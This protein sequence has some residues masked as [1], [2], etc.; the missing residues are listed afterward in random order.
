M[1]SSRP[2][3]LTPLGALSLL[4]LVP[5]AAGGSEGGPERACLLSAYALPQEIVKPLELVLLSDRSFLITT[6]NRVFWQLQE[7]GGRLEVVPETRG[8][9]RKRFEPTESSSFRTRARRVR[10]GS[11]LPPAAPT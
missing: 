3:F 11:S 1:G 6:E 10:T 9:L 7:R 8:W 5:A 4:L 2:L